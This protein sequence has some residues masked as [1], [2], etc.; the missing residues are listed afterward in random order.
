M[1]GILN[2][3]QIE[4]LLKSQTFGRIGCHADGETYIV[5]ISYAYDGNYIYCHTNEGKKATMLRKNPSVCFE[6]E[7]MKT[8]ANW[9]CVVVQ[10]V[11]EEL[12]DQ[13][14]RNEAMQTL[15]NRYL[16]IISSV[17]THLGELWPFYPNDTKDINGVVFRIAVK[18]KTGRF[19][20]SEQ[21]PTI[22]G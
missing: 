1:I 20:S 5:P 19:E 15:L 7:E 12:K 21:S 11:F 16:P 10:G 6:V 18:E 8:M 2:P 17:T 14:E 9:K 4:E 3:Q 13:K 22:P